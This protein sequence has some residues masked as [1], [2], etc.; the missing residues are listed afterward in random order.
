MQ[1]F[2]TVDE[3]INQLKPEKPI[4]CIRKKS[5]QSASTYFRNKFP[6]KVLYAVKTNSHPE[7]LKTIVESGIEN[8]D[9]ASVQE[10]KDI[11]AISPDAKCSYMH[12]VKSRESIKEAYFNYNIKAFSL[13]TKDE[14][15]KIIE[16]TNQAKDLELFVRVAVSNEHAQID[17][18]KKFGVLTS[19]ATGLLR[20]TKQYAKKIGLS[21][22][23]GSQCMHPI[24]YA[25]GI[26][27]IGNIIKKTKII[28]D[29]INIGGGFPAIYPDLVPQPLENY[30]E[31][32]KKSLTNLELEKLPELLCEPG[33]AIVAE[34]GSTI[35]RVNLRK[36]QKLYINDGTYGTLFD[37]G[38]PNMVYPSR[39]IKSSKII[40]KKLT[41]FDFYGPTCDSMDYMKGPFL[42]PNNIKENDYIEL[43]QLG[44]YGLTFRTQFNG[45]YSNEIYE[46]EDEPIMTMYG[47]DSNKAILVA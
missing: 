16:A 26:G 30:F 31:E 23:V 14:L 12:T 43:G 25:K 18:S 28:P 32:I 20:L 7:V 44:A 11:R 10:I 6:G 42:L 27:E 1:K 29:Y 19:E 37:A 13:D 8:F 33:R 24:S 36:K 5:I 39:L 47:K 46:V 21:F 38:T 45:F 15:I 3:L 2:K 40:S 22:H 34:S 35:V 4:Y 17:L 9:V 41:A